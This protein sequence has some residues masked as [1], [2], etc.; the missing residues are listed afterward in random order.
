MNDTMKYVVSAT[1]D[2]TTWQNSEII[3]G[4]DAGVI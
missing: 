3:G 1:L 4:Y 2:K